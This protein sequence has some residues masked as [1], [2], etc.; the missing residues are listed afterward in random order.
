MNGIWL[1]F[2]EIMHDGI[3]WKKNIFEFW[4][5]INLKKFGSPMNESINQK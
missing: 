1:R 2:V 3:Y 5:N 4:L